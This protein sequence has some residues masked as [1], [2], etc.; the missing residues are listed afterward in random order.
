MS[1][2]KTEASARLKAAGVFQPPSIVTPNRKSGPRL[3]SR[4]KDY[5]SMTGNTKGFHR[6][7]SNKK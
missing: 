7:G 5:D 1:K 6:P 4:Q 2:T 3:A